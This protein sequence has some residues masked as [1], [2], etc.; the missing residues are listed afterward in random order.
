MIRLPRWAGRGTGDGGLQGAVEVVE[1]RGTTGSRCT[2]D[3]TVGVVDHLLHLLLVLLEGVA[4]AVA[5]W[6]VV[7][8]TAVWAAVVTAVWAVAVTVVWAVAVTEEVVIVKNS[9]GTMP[10]DSSS[11][12]AE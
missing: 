2:E 12:T 11:P 1:A 9:P 3:V 4:T 6:V 7:E 8:V 10:S 5:V